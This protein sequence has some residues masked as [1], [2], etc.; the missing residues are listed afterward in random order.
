MASA[1]A[2]LLADRERLDAMADAA[3]RRARERF[4]WD[5]KVDRWRTLLVGDVHAD[6]HEGPSPL[7]LDG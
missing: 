1:V 7:D 6:V 5:E 3:R 4:S 2:D